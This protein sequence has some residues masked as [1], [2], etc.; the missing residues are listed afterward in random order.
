MSS[1]FSDRL[2]KLNKKKKMNSNVKPFDT[3]FP[4]TPEDKKLVEE[5]LKEYIPLEAS[6]ELDKKLPTEDFR[7]SPPPIQ[8]E[9]KQTVF[10]PDSE[11]IFDK[12]LEKIEEK[13]KNQNLDFVTMD[14]IN[15]ANQ[16]M[17]NFFTEKFNS[18][19]LSFAG[20][21]GEPK[22]NLNI[23]LGQKILALLNKYVTYSH[24]RLNSL[25]N[26]KGL[27]VGRAD[28]LIIVRALI[29]QELEKEGLV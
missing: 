24:K 9:S 5:E 16:E 8:N 4:S 20:N 19:T 7:I 21:P 14:Q 10:Y 29:M 15:Q 2:N 6:T 13:A 26:S 1:N 18:L 11:E 27:N 28:K 23:D 3:R 17:K 12:M 22:T 25:A